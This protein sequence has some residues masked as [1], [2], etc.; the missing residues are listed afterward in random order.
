VQARGLQR[1][2]SSAKTRSCQWP[3]S[4]HYCLSRRDDAES[5][6]DVCSK[7]SDF[8]ILLSVVDTG[9]GIAPEN[10]ESIFDPF[11]QMEQRST[12]RAGGTGLGLS[13]SRSLARLPSGEVTIQSTPKGGSIFNLELPVSPGGG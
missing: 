13:V 9:I 5:R 3:E 12:R 1:N 7:H 10:F 4:S 2:L 11:W 6:I 8:S